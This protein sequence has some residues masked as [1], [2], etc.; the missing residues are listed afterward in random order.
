[1]ELLL[2]AEGKLMVN[3]NHYFGNR[4]ISDMLGY[5]K[6]RENYKDGDGNPIVIRSIGIMKMHID[7]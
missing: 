7:Y 5:I 1:M 6:Q 2:N 4:D 3:M